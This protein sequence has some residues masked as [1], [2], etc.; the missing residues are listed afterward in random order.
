MKKN[1]FLIVVCLISALF[2]CNVERVLDEQSFTSKKATNDNSNDVVIIEG[3]N[4]ATED[5]DE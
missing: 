3:E 2:S 1:I 4:E 5:S